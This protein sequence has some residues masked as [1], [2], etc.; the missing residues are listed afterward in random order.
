MPL[1]ENCGVEV[2]GSWLDKNG[3]CFTCREYAGRQ[4]LRE[5]RRRGYLVPLPPVPN[6]WPER[7]REAIVKISQRRG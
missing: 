4:R 2:E 5:Q 6:P 3:V 7:L 1:C